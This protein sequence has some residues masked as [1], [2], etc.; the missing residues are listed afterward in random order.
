MGQEC[1]HPATRYEMASIP[2]DWIARFP[3]AEGPRQRQLIKDFHDLRLESCSS[4]S[5][6]VRRRQWIM[7][8][9]AEIDAE[10]TRDYGELVQARNFLLGL[11]ANDVYSPLI[12][13]YSALCSDS[14]DHE[15]SMSN[16]YFDTIVQQAVRAE[17]KAAKKDAEKAEKRQRKAARRQRREAKETRRSAVQEI[18]AEN[19]VAVES[20][21]RHGVLEEEQR[22]AAE[23]QLQHEDNA[24]ACDPVDQVLPRPGADTDEDDVVDQVE[25]SQGYWAGINSDNAADGNPPGSSNHESE[26]DQQATN[27]A[28]NLNS[29]DMGD[30]YDA[31]AYFQ[32]GSD[33]G[34]EATQQN[35]NLARGEID[36]S[37]AHRQS[38]VGDGHGSEP[39][40][41]RREVTPF[42]HEELE[43]VSGSEGGPHGHNQRAPEETA[44][45]ARDVARETSPAVDLGERRSVVDD[46][47]RQADLD[48]ADDDDA[49]PEVSSGQAPRLS[50]EPADAAS[51]PRSFSDQLRRWI[52][53]NRSLAEE[54][55]GPKL[56][57]WLKER[58]RRRSPAAKEADL[59][60]QFYDTFFLDCDSIFDYIYRFD[61]IRD[62]ISSENS[63]ASAE[64]SDANPQHHVAL[65]DIQLVEKFL[66]GLT[67]APAPY[68]DFELRFRAL[69]NPSKAKNGYRNWVSGKNVG[70][71]Q[72]KN[73]LMEETLVSYRLGEAGVKYEEE[74]SQDSSKRAAPESVGSSSKRQRN[75]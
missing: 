32:N 70:F 9:L 69:H 49:T 47:V 74:E 63:G 40:R 71:D 36:N 46:E 43:N 59:I 52:D 22:D 2:E 10:S 48:E 23:L 20:D 3:D 45:D 60:R 75:H 66:Q 30:D 41:R 17:T 16:I 57:I 64:S 12:Q 72:V 34:D 11:P 33:D 25:S 31:E 27:V 4:V 68:C 61:F 39:S 13:K 38:N 21:G 51:Q 8:E 73:L 1:S 42:P 24:D 54:D 14:W 5:D 37:V 28:E 19:G 29:D 18:Q 53:S 26:A 67:V 55:M 50:R 6:Y 58:K 7:L 56:L 62:G 44:E 65:T 15:D 35:H